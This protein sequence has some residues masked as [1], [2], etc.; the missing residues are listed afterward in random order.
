MTAHLKDE[1]GNDKLANMTQDEILFH[2]F[3]IYDGN[4]DGRIDGIDIYKA[5]TSHHHDGI[6][7]VL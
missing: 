6:S 1:L 5:M 4:K 3:R 7:P 2:Y